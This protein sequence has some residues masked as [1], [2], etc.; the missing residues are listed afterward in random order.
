ME[1]I[2]LYRQICK[3]GLNE[4]K[5]INQPTIKKIVFNLKELEMYYNDR[6][7]FYSKKNLI[8][9]GGND[10]TCSNIIMVGGGSEELLNML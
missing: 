8:E 1:R 2:K 10:C 9:G 6:F 5:P 4:R 3:I 7:G